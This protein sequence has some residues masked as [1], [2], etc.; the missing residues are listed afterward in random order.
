MFTSTQEQHAHFVCDVRILLVS[1][2]LF[3]VCSLHSHRILFHMPMVMVAHSSHQATAI[4][5]VLLGAR[6]TVLLGVRWISADIQSKLELS[7]KFVSHK[8][9]TK[10]MCT[11][12][13]YNLNQTKHSHQGSHREN[14]RLGLRMDALKHYKL[15]AVVILEPL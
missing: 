1:F 8:P 3:F 15:P 9:V 6:A 11:R 13:Q 4:S 12:S 7:R 5:F 2:L 10:Y 14:K